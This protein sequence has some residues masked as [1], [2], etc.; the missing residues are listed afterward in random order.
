MSHAELVAAITSAPAVPAEIRE[1]V[2][3]EFH[4][5]ANLPDGKRLLSLIVETTHLPNGGEVTMVYGTAVV[6]HGTGGSFRVELPTELA[7]R[8]LPARAA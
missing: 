3:V 8:Y 4:P 2:R 1:Q 6:P 5:A 7:D